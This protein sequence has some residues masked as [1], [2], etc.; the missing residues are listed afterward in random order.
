MSNFKS[1][2]A[3][4]QRV[5]DFY[6]SRKDYDNDLTRE[7]ALRHLELTHLKPGQLVLDVAT[8]T[9]NIAIAAAQIVGNEGSVIG[10]D[11]ATDLLAI[12]QQKI[13][14]AGLTNIQ[15]ITIDAEDYQAE[16]DQFDAIFCSYAIVL[17]SD[18]SAILEKWYQWLKSGGFIA[19]TSFA[20]NAFLT[21]VKV[22]V[23]HRYGVTLPNLHFPLG[24]PERC[25]QLLSKIGFHTIKV[26]S[27]QRGTYLSLEQAKKR[28]D[29]RF[30]LHPDDPLPT[31]AAETVQQIKAA[32]DSEL[33]ALA[34]EQGIW[35]EGMTFYVTA[36]KA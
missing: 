7:R 20:E 14:A 3:Y 9:G 28:W 26:Y 36:E 13:Q 1:L 8:G 16:S 17:F 21:P 23:C 18:I 29:G 22:E 6:N 19:F 24:T 25:E 35:D 4:K 31:L 11:I 32:Y 12:A 33:E 2:E 5:V 30:W 34:T 27:E 15:L 10:I